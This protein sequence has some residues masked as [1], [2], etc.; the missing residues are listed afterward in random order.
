MADYS[1]GSEALDPKPLMWDSW[2]HLKFVSI[3]ETHQENVAFT[4]LKLAT[5]LEHWSLLHKW[6]NQLSSHMVML[7]NHLVFVNP[8]KLLPFQ[9]ATST[10]KSTRGFR[11]YTDWSGDVVAFICLG[12]AFILDDYTM[13][14]YFWHSSHLDILV[15]FPTSFSLLL[16]SNLVFA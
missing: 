4:T 3:W 5:S 8:T 13:I 14:L 10:F 7:P 9:V 15:H 11:L 2:Q 12:V 1:F 6:L 16:F